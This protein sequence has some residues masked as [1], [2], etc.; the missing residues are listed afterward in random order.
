MDQEQ[1][2]A[3]VKIKHEEDMAKIKENH[4]KRLNEMEIKHKNEMNNL[5]IE[6][7]KTKLKILENQYSNK[8]NIN[9][10]F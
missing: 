7:N 5:E 4:L 3:V 1:R 6:I 9:L 10:R 2:L 8:E